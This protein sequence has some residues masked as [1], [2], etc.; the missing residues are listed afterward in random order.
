MTRRVALSDENGTAL[1]VKGYG[2]PDFS[3]CASHFSAEQ[4]TEKKHHFE[5][6]KEPYTILNLDGRFTAHS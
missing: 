3:F 6:E 4:L 2:V 5:L 1:K